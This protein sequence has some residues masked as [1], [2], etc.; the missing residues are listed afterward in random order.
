S[1]GEVVEE[2]EDIK[3]VVKTSTEVVFKIQIAAS[4]KDLEP[5]SFNF[6]G[7]SPIS[8]ENEKS[9]Y[10]YYFGNT[11]TYDQAKKLKKK[12]RRKGYKHAFIVAFKEN[13]KI[14]LSTVIQR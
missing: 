12:A 13:E 10:R 11:T 8:R 2:V 9:L 1:I 6:K 4:S 7:L 3:E 14:K 5:K